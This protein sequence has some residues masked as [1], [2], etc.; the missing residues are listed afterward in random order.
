[1]SSFFGHGAAALAISVAGSTTRSRPLLWT[2]WLGL[3]AAAPD[4]DYL[5]PSLRSGNPPVRVTHSWLGA[6]VLPMLTVA[7]IWVGRQRLVAW[8][9][10]VCQAATAGAS[11]VLL[12]L[13]VGVTALP[14][15][16]PISD[17]RYVL[18]FGVLPSAGRLG[19]HNEL[20]WRNLA[21][22]AG[23]FLPVV[24]VVAVARMSRL[25]T[26]IRA[27]SCT[28]LGAVSIAFVI[29]AAGLSR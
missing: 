8:K 2:A 27:L 29:Q 6:L 9:A 13:L 21:I 10:L 25:P 22:E 12:D 28:L 17:T 15:W 26:P 1:M 24:A 18:P 5:V 20:L 7:V 16:W 19:V 11:H 3:L 14:L 23:I 4:I